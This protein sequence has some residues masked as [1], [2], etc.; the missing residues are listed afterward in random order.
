M[1]INVTQVLNNKPEEISAWL[2]Q[3]KQIL[4]DHGYE[5]DEL[6]ALLP[7]VLRLLSSKTVLQAAPQRVELPAHLLN[8]H[9]GV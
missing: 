8:G 6:V 7:E 3:G 9:P 4:V 1:N 2:E 5:G